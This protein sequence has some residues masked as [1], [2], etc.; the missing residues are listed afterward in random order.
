MGDTK[1][2]A[3][4]VAAYGVDMLLAGFAYFLLTRALVALHGA[5][6]QLA[7]AVGRDRKGLLSLLIY[8]AAIPTAFLDARLACGLYVLVAVLWLIPDRRIESTLTKG[9]SGDEDGPPPGTDH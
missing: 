1:F 2:H 9:A 6:S 7:R 3:W 8:A 4:P 5:E